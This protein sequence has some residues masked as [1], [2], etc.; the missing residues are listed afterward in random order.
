MTISLLHGGGILRI[1]YTPKF[2]KPYLERNACTL[3]ASLG[4]S[5]KTSKQIHVYNSMN[6]LNGSGL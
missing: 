6:K 5:K 1:L 2:T 4:S 3:A